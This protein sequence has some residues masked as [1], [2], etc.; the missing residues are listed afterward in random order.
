[1]KNILKTILSVVVLI[2][3]T[4][5]LK[6]Q[7]AFNFASGQLTYTEDFN[8]M[9][10][11]GTSFILG[12]TA[13]R[14]A[15][16]GSIG[17][18][19]T[20]MVSDGSG[21]SGGIYNLGTTSAEDRA[22]GSLGSG[23]TIPAYGAMFKNSTGAN[24]SKVDMTAVMEQWR[25][26]SSNTANEITKF[27]Y[28][29]DAT[30]LLTGTWIA[31]SSMDLVELN[32]GSAEAAPLDGNLPANQSSI[33][34]TINDLVWPSGATL[35]IRWTDA[36][37][38]GS[39]GICA[40]D[41]LSVTV[42]TGEVVIDPEP[43]NYPTGF[44]ASA[45]GLS[46][47]VGF[48][49]ATGT[50]L[51]AGYL[52]K[53]STSSDITAPVDGASVTD[54]LD[55]NDGNGAKNIA[56]GIGDY[57]FQRLSAET[58]YYLAIF[59][60]TNYGAAIDFKTDGTAPAANI[61]SPEIIHQQ[62]FEDGLSPWTSYSVTGAQEWTVDSTNGVD[63]TK[64]MKMNGYSGGALDNQDW[65]ISSAIDASD[66]SD[67]RLQFYSAK[68]YAG[69]D[70]Q[71]KVSSDY[72]SG[73]PTTATW[74]DLASLAELSTGGWAWTP[75]GFFNPGVDQTA[76]IHFAFIYTSSTTAAPAWEI[77]NVLLTGNKQVGINEQAQ[78]F[79]ANLYPNPCK[80]RFTLT[81]PEKDTYFVTIY[82]DLGTVVM[83]KEVNSQ[84]SQIT[85]NQLS[86]GTY[87]V[88]IRNTSTGKSLVKALTIQ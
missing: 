73:D 36:N 69:D 54:D 4:L 82:S 83:S 68:N 18:V 43:S 16:T 81:L 15:G 66:Y 55:L 67:L 29:L 27:E 8:S 19:L 13:V 25:S 38:V 1:M 40:V 88:K 63:G 35:W 41:N 23:S 33:S 45:S 37:D 2:A 17:Q 85:V 72:S 46:C 87:W 78:P 60:Y 61:L 11:T 28:S 39:D 51:P 77:D 52:I 86:S 30:D 26:G 47:E 76:N 21:N 58:K 53:I 80:D 7:E 44:N 22:L 32:T 50:Q 14:S 3:L 59:P 12:W 34:G 49:D 71:V 74:N 24:I 65:L 42:T 5:P 31:L 62:T 20:L 84:L 79:A 70:L 6:A 57:T 75:S 64:C 48:S 10:A 9:E 56:Y